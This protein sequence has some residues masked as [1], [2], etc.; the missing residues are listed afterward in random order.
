[1][2]QYATPKQ[3]QLFDYLIRLYFGDTSDPLSCCIK[4]A[5]RDMNRTLHGLSELPADK[6]LHGRAS[7][8]VR[9]FLTGLSKTGGVAFDK[10][11]RDACYELCSTYPSAKFRFH[12]GQAQK[13]LNMSLKYVF[14]FGEDRLPGYSR[15]F[16]LAHI[17]LDNIILGHPK[18]NAAPK[19][20]TRW[21]RVDSYDEYMEVQLWV[22]RNFPDSPPLAVEFDLWQ[23]VNM[24][25]VQD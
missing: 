11:H 24:S 21:S 17:P 1:M 5:Y 16:A 2:R 19:L 8:V 15:I 10:R 14:V 12:I 25:D 4:R 6:G 23:N 13:W 7:A 20:S 3:A 18:M 9:S 22:R